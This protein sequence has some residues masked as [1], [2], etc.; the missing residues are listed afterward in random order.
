MGLLRQVFGPSQDEIWSQLAEQ[1]GGRFIDGGFWKGD[2]VVARAGQWTVTLDTFTVSH[3]RNRA[4]YTRL[5]APFENP[6]GFHFSVGREHVFSGIARWL[7]F[8][9]LEIGEAEFDAA[10][11]IRGDQEDKV[12][13]FFANPRL[14]SLLMR[15]P[16]VAFEVQRGDS[17]VFGNDL[18]EGVDQLRFVSPG[19]IKDLDQLKQL[20]SLFAIALNQI[21]H[22]GSA[23]EDDPELAA[24]KYQ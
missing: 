3:G 23:Y 1:L 12:R 2:A 16:S 20:F 10:F 14:R 24:G 8:Q 21:S 22:I 11:V 7:G 13:A 4:T 9:D 19:V 5:L 18:P 17:G 15:Q 6:D